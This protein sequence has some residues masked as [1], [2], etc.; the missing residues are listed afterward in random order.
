[1]KVQDF[2]S[3]SIQEYPFLYKDVDYE[4]SKVKVL[5][6]IFFT[7]GNGLEM[8]ATDNPQEGGYVVEPKYKRNKKTNGWNRIKDKPYSKEKYKPIPNGY[9]DSVVYYVYSCEHPLEVVYRKSEYNDDEFLFRYDKKVDEKF[10][11]PKFYKAESLHKFHPY[12]FS[13]NFSIAC[14][15][16]YNNI[17]LQDDWMQELIFLCE[18][19]LLFFNDEAEYKNDCYYPSEKSIKKD[20]NCFNERFKKEGL[21][22]LN[23]LQ[24]SWGY[25][26]K[27]SVPSY[28]EIEITKNKSWEYYLNKQRLFLTDFLKKYST[29]TVGS[30]CR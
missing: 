24:K 25:K 2:I 6:Q 20:L 7:I 3:K 26:I 8:A 9:F 28:E 18:R 4:K 22:G 21:K 12:P 11:E 17:F 14:D 10:R 15:V 27:D 23:D 30:S 5:S 13:K 29:I 1:M 19:T 16:F